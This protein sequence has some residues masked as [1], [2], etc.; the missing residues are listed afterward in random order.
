MLPKHGH[1]TREIYLEAWD[2]RVV[3]ENLRAIGDYCP[4]LERIDL[5]YPLRLDLTAT[6]Q[7]LPPKFEIKA[8][9]TTEDAE[10]PDTLEE[11]VAPQADQDVEMPDAIQIEEQHDGPAVGQAIGQVAGPAD[12]QLNAGQA[13]VGQTDGQGNVQTDVQTDGVAVGQ[14]DG[15]VDGQ[16]DDDDAAAGDSDIDSDDD[17]DDDDD[18]DPNSAAAAAAAAAHAARMAAAQAQFAAQKRACA[19]IDYIIK[20][21]P[22]LQCFSIQWT[23]PPALQ[24][25]YQKIPK[26]NA[27]RIW[28]PISDEDLIATGKKCRDLQRFYLDGQQRHGITL[29]GMIRF[30]NALHTKDKSKLKNLGLSYPSALMVNAHGFAM[31]MDNDDEDD[32]MGD[33]DNGDEDMGGDDGAD[34]GDLDIHDNGPANIFNLGIGLA[35]LPPPMPAP[36][37]K[38]LLREFLEVLSVKHPFLERLCLVGCEIKDELIDVLGRFDHLQ[39]LDI[40]KPT[41][42]GLSA[43]GISDLVSMFRGKS[44]TSLDLSRHRQMSEDDMDI[45]T[46]AEGLK[47]LRYIKVEHCPHLKDKYMMDE[48]V[49]PDDFV[50]EDGTWRPRQGAGKSLLE[51]GDGFK[52]QWNE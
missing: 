19:E 50:M 27:L 36:E 20:N 28:D 39:S 41:N 26:L 12:G 1:L 16:A 37:P 46:G 9:Q 17:D 14:A 22:M 30:L 48:W 49:H 42:E 11:Q 8:E 2:R 6:E 13:L 45:L 31:D 7:D 52:E 5:N 51:I 35:H 34:N 40:S 29:N 23:G 18:A 24:R 15:Q 10:P 38:S 47:T 44:L 3:Y 4:N 32:G 43:V 33:M 21:C 25:F